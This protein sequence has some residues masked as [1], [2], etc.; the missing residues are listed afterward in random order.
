MCTDKV[1]INRRC[2]LLGQL[3]IC[4]LHTS[5]LQLIIVLVLYFQC[6]WRQTEDRG[7]GVMEGLLTTS[8]ALGHTAPT[9]DG[10]VNFASYMGN[11]SATKYDVFPIPGNLSTLVVPTTNTT[12]NSTEVPDYACYSIY[13]TWRQFPYHAISQD[14]SLCVFLCL[15]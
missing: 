13:A 9:R 1:Q 6:D 11:L 14:L 5:P 4:G 3:F 12:D 8:S 15:W 10:A 7:T 2:S